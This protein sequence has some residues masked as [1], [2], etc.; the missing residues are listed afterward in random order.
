LAD[1]TYGGENCCGHWYEITDDMCDSEEIFCV[2]IEGGARLEGQDI[3]NT[4]LDMSEH[5]RRFILVDVQLTEYKWVVADP[6]GTVYSD[7]DEDEDEDKDD[8]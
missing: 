6:K 5:T 8:E 2:E 1:A 7:A 3:A 4:I